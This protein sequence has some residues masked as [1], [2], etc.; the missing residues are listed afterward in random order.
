MKLVKIEGSWSSPKYLIK[1]YRSS[2]TSAT[3]LSLLLWKKGDIITHHY[4]P[5]LDTLVLSL[6]DGQSEVQHVT[7]IILDD[8]VH[9]CTPI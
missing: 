4:R 9:T 8:H 7:G 3:R 1:Q 5:N 6:L 2:Q